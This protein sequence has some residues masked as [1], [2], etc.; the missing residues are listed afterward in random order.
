MLFTM[1]T[2][3]SKY[4]EKIRDNAF[5]NENYLSI[6]EGIVEIL[7]YSTDENPNTTEIKQNLIEIFKVYVSYLEQARKKIE[8][9]RTNGTS[10]FTNKDINT[11]ISL[12]III[13]TITKSAFESLNEQNKFIMTLIFGTGMC[14]AMKVIGNSM[15]L[16]IIIGININALWNI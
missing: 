11:L 12:L 9:Q 15:I 10:E 4:N 13:K 16:G 14:L 5:Q 2:N 1:S 6:L 8:I 3:V 7:C